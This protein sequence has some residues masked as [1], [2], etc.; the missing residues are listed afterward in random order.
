MHG[1]LKDSLEDTFV[2]KGFDKQALNATLKRRFKTG[3]RRAKI[4]ARDQTSKTIGKLTKLR[5]QQIGIKEYDWFTSGDERVRED[6][7]MMHGTRQNWEITPSTGHPGEAV[8]CRCVAIPVI[9]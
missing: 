8:M 2:N 5:H 1:S 4:I 9:E 6:H 7:A 3:E